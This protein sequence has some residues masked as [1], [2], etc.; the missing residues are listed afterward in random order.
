MHLYTKVII[1]AKF[2]LKWSNIAIT[3]F[4]T[5]HWDQ[6]YILEGGLTLARWIW[7][8]LG[9]GRSLGCGNMCAKFQ[10]IWVLLACTS[11][12]KVSAGQKLCEFCGRAWLSKWG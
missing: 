1:C 4:A 10:V 11:F 7:L 12:T 2:Q 8:K 5:G 6:K 9:L 3:S